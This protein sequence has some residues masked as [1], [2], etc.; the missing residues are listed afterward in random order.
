M[1]PAMVPLE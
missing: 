1:S